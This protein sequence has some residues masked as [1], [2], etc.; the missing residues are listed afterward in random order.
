MDYQPLVN[1]GPD[2]SFA[3]A[4]PSV[5]DTEAYQP[6]IDLGSNPMLRHAGTARANI[7]PS[8]SAPSGTTEREWTKQHSHQTVMQQHCNFFD[9]DHDGIIWPK[10]T[11]IGFYRLGFGVLLSMFAMFA[12]HGALSYNTQ[13]SILPDPFFRILIQNIHKDKHGSDS[14]TYD[15]EG[16][17]VPQKFEDIFAKFASGRDY[18]TA[19]E[20]YVMIRQNMCAFDPFGW[21]AEALEWTATY[22]MLWPSDGR[23]M[24]EDIRGM[25]DGSIFYTIAARREK[26]Q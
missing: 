6:F 4:I 7:A 14:G 23:M 10:D 20:V 11:Y 19:G 9:Q 15:T 12:I 1:G 17:Y 2:D 26:S 16:R 22:I 21:T 3:R 8:T 24:K 13:P 5:P 18:I 25:Y